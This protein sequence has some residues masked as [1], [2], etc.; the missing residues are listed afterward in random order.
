[1]WTDK[2]CL[3][4]FLQSLLIKVTICQVKMCMIPFCNK[5]KISSKSLKVKI[6]LNLFGTYKEVHQV[7]LFFF[8]IE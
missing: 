7:G 5:S 2:N 1:M 3:L 4:P 6:S 8:S